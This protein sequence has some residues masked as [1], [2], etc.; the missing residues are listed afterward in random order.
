[1]TKKRND[2]KKCCE[3]NERIV[4]KVKQRTKR[5]GDER[6]IKGKNDEKEEG[7]DNDKR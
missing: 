3:V 4:L 1:M 2:K 6:K 5:N 7:K